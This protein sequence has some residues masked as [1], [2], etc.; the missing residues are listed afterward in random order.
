VASRHRGIERDPVLHEKH[1]LSDPE[2]STIQVVATFATV[3]SFL[4]QLQ[5]SGHCDICDF[6]ST[7]LLLCR[8]I[9]EIDGDMHFRGT[10]YHRWQI[11]AL[12]ALQMACEHFL[13]GVLNQ[14]N[15]AAI[16]A[17]RVT[18]T[19]KDIQLIKRIRGDQ[20]PQIFGTTSMN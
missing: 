6:L 14:A 13:V 18:I 9:R 5:D 15:L 1:R 11:L 7:L 4:H 8:L 3:L 19:P 12:E 2:S 16:H 17:K 20:E 10:G